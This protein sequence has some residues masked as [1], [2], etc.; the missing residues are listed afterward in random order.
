VCRAD[1]ITRSRA[2]HPFGVV[3][4]VS[5]QTRHAV[6]DALPVVFPDVFP[7]AGDAPV[8]RPP[9]SAQ[10]RTDIG[11]LLASPGFDAWSEVLSRVGNC[12]RPI[13]PYGHSV[14]ID[15]ATGEIVRSYAS[16]QD[17]FGVTHI[18]CGNRRATACPSCSR[19]YAADM[20]HLIRA[21]VTGGK[22]VPDTV[23][24]NPLVFATLTAP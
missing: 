18:R 4:L 20:F 15:T 21:G 7:G 24:E 19:L 12:A 5:S 10:T 6:Y 9:A 16:S 13:R 22:S 3:R 2:A 8:D 11:E 17:P 14:T 1:G 23:A